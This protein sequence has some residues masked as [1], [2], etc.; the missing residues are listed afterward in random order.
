MIRYI[1]LAFLAL[2]A[3]VAHGQSTDSLRREASSMLRA[4][5]Y[6]NAMLLLNKALVAEPD[7]AD[8]R[9]ELGMACYQG[10]FF[11]QGL[12]AVKPLVDKPD[13]DEQAFQIAGMLCKEFGD[14]KEADRIYK[15]GI[16]K[17]P[18]YGPLYSDYGEML[19]QRH[20][21]YGDAVDVWEKGIEM[22]P[23]YPGNYYNAARYYAGESEWIWAVVYGEIFVNLESYS[24]RTPEIK[25]MLYDGYQK[26]MGGGLRLKMKSNFEK[27]VAKIFTQQG[28]LINK[29]VNPETLAAIR[30]RFILN[31]YDGPGQKMPFRLYDMHRQLLQ[32]GLFEAYNQWLFGSVAD[33]PAYQNWTTRHS[34]VMK[35]FY[36]Y[37]RSRVFTV[38]N[39]QYYRL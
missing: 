28:D 25:E 1:L 21:G 26:L 35:A 31:W 38:P 37:Q 22:T 10:G 29:G 19:E 5:D 14:L 15:A 7:N 23:S 39:G 17:F 13:A 20:P 27:E 3:A 8:I 4:G 33:L 18:A 9:K 24:V 11:K 34:D 16:K 6:G 30:T 12:E 2:G 36:E 32:E